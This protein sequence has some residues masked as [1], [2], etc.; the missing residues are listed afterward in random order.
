MLKENT[1]IK[2]WAY[3]TTEWDSAYTTSWNDGMFQF[4]GSHFDM[5]PYI[6]FINGTVLKDPVVKRDLI[7][8]A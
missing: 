4:K 6:Y 1:G 8:D 7:Q 2:Y 5:N 3:K